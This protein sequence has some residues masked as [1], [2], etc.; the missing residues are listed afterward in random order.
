MQNYFHRVQVPCYCCVTWYEARTT[1]FASLF[2]FEVKRLWRNAFA[3]GKGL[4]MEFCCAFI[5]TFLNISI[6]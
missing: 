4:G 6:W 5:S 1:F 2:S 3:R